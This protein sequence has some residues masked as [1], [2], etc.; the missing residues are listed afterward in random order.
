MLHSV[1]ENAG[2]PG[3]FSTVAS[4]HSSTFFILVLFHALINVAEK[5]IA[6]NIRKKCHV[7][8]N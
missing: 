7:L 8:S 6:H 2:L 1:S 4:S 3:Y 5:I